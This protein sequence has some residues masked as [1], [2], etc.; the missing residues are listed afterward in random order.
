MMVVA[1]WYKGFERSLKYSKLEGRL[2][3]YLVD[4]APYLAAS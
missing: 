2:L 1:V 3:V 4:T